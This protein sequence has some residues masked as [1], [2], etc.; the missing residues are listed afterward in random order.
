VETDHG[1]H[2]VS[3][4][5]RNACKLLRIKNFSLQLF[6][7]NHRGVFAEVTAYLPREDQMNWD[8]CVPFA[9]HA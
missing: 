9:A 5:F 6:I 7:R 3:E 4:V 1:A 8:E 2:F